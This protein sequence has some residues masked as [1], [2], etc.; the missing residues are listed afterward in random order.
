A[1][2]LFAFYVQTF[3]SYGKTYGALGGVI[4]LV[5]WF[6]LSSIIIVVG[7]EMNA[8][9]ERQMRKDAGVARRGMPSPAQGNTTL[10]GT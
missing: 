6:Y 5:M 1:S 10:A 4:A 3:A 8:E 2:G 7:A 9:M